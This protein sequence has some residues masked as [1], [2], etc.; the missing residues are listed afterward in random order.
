[1]NTHDFTITLQGRPEMDESAMDRLFEAGCDDATLVERHGARRLVFS[2]KAESFAS[3]VLTAIENIHAAGL[4]VAQ[5]DE[6]N[7]VTQAEI[8]RRS[9]RT[10]Q[11]VSQLIAGRRGPGGFPVPIF[12]TADDE[13]LWDWMSVAS[14]LVSNGYV[15]PDVG[16]RAALLATVNS[17]LE[18]KRLSKVGAAKRIRG[19]FKLTSAAT[20]KATP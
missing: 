5:V 1:M 6:P 11:S 14:W 12:C 19:A 2:R 9:G 3:A 17:E 13:P 15:S 8:A 18:H 20:G 4:V 16:D 7:L 10:R